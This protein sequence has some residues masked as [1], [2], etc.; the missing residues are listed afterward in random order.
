MLAGWDGWLLMAAVCC[1]ADIDIDAA[2]ES[3]SGLKGLPLLYV[4]KSEPG[5][6]ALPIART[7]FSHPSGWLKGR[8]VPPRAL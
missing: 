2:R 6:G 7:P 8:E 4:C 1:A 3:A 5:R